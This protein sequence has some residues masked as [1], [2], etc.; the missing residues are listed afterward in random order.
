MIF[1]DASYLVALEVESDSN[2]EKAIK[3]RDRLI[4]GEFGNSFISD[5]IFD[6]TMTVTFGKIK[7]LE[8][9]ASAGT[10]LRN[11]SV[12]VKIDES[13]F[14]ETWN[15]FRKQE[16]TKLSF[17]DCS[18]LVIMKRMGIKSIATFDEG[19]DKIK[20]VNVVS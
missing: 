13:D 18:N 8:R 20:E 12:L 9:A 2:H 1:L 10:D 3:I 5:Y 17:T 16:G 6:E 14:E 19:F 15:L 7:N 11:S 4:K